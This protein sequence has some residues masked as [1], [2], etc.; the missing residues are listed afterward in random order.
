[1]S[2]LKFAFAIFV[3]MSATPQETYANQLNNYERKIV[4]DAIEA[5]EMCYHWAGEV[6]E[7]DQER[8]KRIAHG[9]ERDCP[10]ATSKARNA[11]SK[12]PN[13]GELINYL[14]YLMYIGYFDVPEETK[15]DM[16]ARSFDYYKEM[17]E[18]TN[19]EDDFYKDY[20]HKQAEILYRK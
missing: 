10:V 4:S 20:C 19:Y 6:G 2:F 9:F 17:F 13:N 5:I 3:I 16:C 14:F 12:Y 11:Y 15:N 1:M 18:S 8:Q 7:G